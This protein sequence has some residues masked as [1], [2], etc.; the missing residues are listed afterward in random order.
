MAFD[1]EV[2]PAER[3]AAMAEHLAAARRARPEALFLVITGGLH[4]VRA[5]SPDFEPMAARLAALLDPSRVV[6]LRLAHAGGDACRTSGWMRSRAAVR[7]GG[8]ND[9][10]R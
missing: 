4:A 7:A 10:G 9:D 5:A 3:D 8:G 6:S 1:A 2:P